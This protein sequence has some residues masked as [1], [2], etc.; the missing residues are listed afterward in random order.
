MIGTPGYTAPEIL[1]GKA[2]GRKSDIFSAGVTLFELLTGENPFKGETVAVTIHNIMNRQLEGVDSDR[3]DVPEWLVRLVTEMTARD[4]AERPQ[5]VRHIIGLIDRSGQRINDTELRNFIKDRAPAAGNEYHRAAA[6]YPV[7]RRL[8]FAAILILVVIVSAGYFFVDRENA[9][10]EKPAPLKELK[11]VP[12]ETI[13]TAGSQGDKN[14]NESVP[15]RP[16]DQFEKKTGESVS[17][18]KLLPQPEERLMTETPARKGGLYISAVPWA[19]VKIDGVPQDTTPLSA[20]IML[21]AGRHELSLENP[22][23]EKYVDTL[24]ISAGRIDSLNIMLSEKYG[25]LQVSVVPWG[26]IYIDKNFIETTPLKS[27]VRIEA[28][29]YVL[30]VKNP[31]FKEYEQNVEVKSGE[32]EYIVVY[33]E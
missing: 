9:V 24:S 20:P 32:T 17:G 19:Y 10:S 27:P 33:L 29:K 11:S 18:A 30:T 16:P 25:Y 13:G 15:V 31:F 7:K 5:S 8:A 2:S 26:E 14:E 6:G 12:V 4:E 22:S 23:F 3:S 1:Q 28:G 21:E